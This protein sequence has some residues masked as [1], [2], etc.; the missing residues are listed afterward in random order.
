MRVLC[1]WSFSS[2]NSFSSVGTLVRLSVEVRLS[3]LTIA[4]GLEE[5][6]ELVGD[7]AFVDAALQEFVAELAVVSGE[8]SSLLANMTISDS[9][10]IP[11]PTKGFSGPS[12]GLHL[13]HHL[14]NGSVKLETGSSRG[15]SA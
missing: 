6:N 12:R 15:E 5:R 3:M 8:N 2:C 13:R 10:S 1:A 14:H 7:G 11:T 9:S 4:V